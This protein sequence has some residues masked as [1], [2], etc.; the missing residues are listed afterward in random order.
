MRRG[1]N[2][3]FV[4]FVLLMSLLALMKWFGV[5]E[6][7]SDLVILIPFLAVVIT[8]VTIAF[9]AVIGSSIGESEE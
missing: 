1:I 7:E 8:V 6:I 9:M 2:E 3:A 5:I 4:T